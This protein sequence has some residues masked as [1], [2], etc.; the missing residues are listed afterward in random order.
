MTSEGIPIH[1]KQP[2]IHTS[3]SEESIL[4]STSEVVLPET[5][6]ET[7]I[8]GSSNI[9]L[10]IIQIILAVF[11]FIISKV[12]LL[13]TF[14]PEIAFLL[15]AIITFF[16]ST[17]KIN[18]ILY[19]II[20][21]T[22]SYL[23]KSSLILL[24][25]G[26]TFGYML[27][28][29]DTS[30]QKKPLLI[31]ESYVQQ[32]TQ[33]S[34]QAIEC[35]KATSSEL[36]ITPRVDDS[37]NKAFDFIIRD[38]IDYY[39]NQISSNKDSEFQIHVRNAMN[40]MAT[41][42][43]LCLQN[44][45]KVELGIMSSFAIAN[46]FIVHLREYKKFIVT[47]ES[48]ST[49]CLQ[50]KN[51]LL[52]HTTDR[53]SQAQV[54]RSL[55]KLLLTRLLPSNEIQSHILMTFLSELWAIQI[56]EAL[57]EKICDSDWLNSAIVSYLTDSDPDETHDTT[58]FQQLATSIDEEVAGLTDK[59]NQPSDDYQSPISSNQPLTIPTSLS[60]NM[61]LDSNVETFDEQKNSSET[62]EEIPL[63]VKEVTD[64]NISPSS[65]SS[66]NPPMHSTNSEEELKNSVEIHP[67]VKEV[68][69]PTTPPSL[70]SPRNSYLRSANTEKLRLILER[71]SDT[72][73]EFMAFLE[74][75]KSANLLRFWLQADSFKKIAANE[76][77]IDLIQNDALRIF[78][79]YF[80]E[81]ALYPV[82]VINDMLVRQCES[83]ISKGP[84]S[85]CFRKLQEYVFVVLENEY[86]DDFIQAMRKQG[87]DMSFMY[88][89][90]PA[91]FGNLSR[92]EDKSVIMNDISI[93]NV[94]HKRNNTV[95]NS[96]LG[97]LNRSIN[98]AESTGLIENRSRSFSTGFFVDALDQITASLGINENF[99]GTHA[100]EENDSE[101][102][103][104][105]PKMPMMN[106]NGV[107]I[108]MTDISESNRLIS[109]TKSRTYMIEVEQP[110]SAGWIMTRSFNDFETLHSALGKDFPKAEKVTMPRLMWKKNHE[111]C[112]SLERYLNILLS[113]AALCES[114]PLQ[115]FMKRDGLPNDDLERTTSKINRAL[116]ILSIPR[117]ISMVNLVG[118]SPHD[119]P[120]NQEF[121]STKTSFEGSY[122]KESSDHFPTYTDRSQEMTDEVSGK[123][124]PSSTFS[125]ITCPSIESRASDESEILP[126]E[127]DT[128]EKDDIPEKEPT[129]EKPRRPR[130][131]K[132]MTG[133]DIDLLIDT[134][135]DTIEEIFD[136]SEKSQWHLRKTVLSVLRGL[137]RRSYTEAIKQYFLT[138]IDSFSTEDYMVSLIDGFTNSFW[139]NGVWAD[140]DQQRS[141]EEK[142]R[143]KDEAKR[144]LLQKAIPNS[145][146][147]V[148]GYEN[149]KNMVGKLVD[150]FLAEK[151]VVRGMGINILE[152]VIKLII[153]G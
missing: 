71:Q 128:P 46:N 60:T 133:Q 87:E 28:N 42:L 141:E 124:S 62:H 138:T 48:L 40:V 65:F 122:S 94:F 63:A 16:S 54:L 39:Y 70:V 106:L 136:L 35:E 89:E 47:N 18:L 139:P 72:F 116:S 127:N 93:E 73:A 23:Q 34:L 114:E 29:N 105:R 81:T 107:R 66:H 144:L 6:Q 112:K 118:A 100:E 137:V 130:P 8:S 83:D 140:F 13:R 19:L 57:L 52:S 20:C 95:D 111:A 38:I 37:L 108:R 104:D 129:L 45:D 131:N 27:R 92:V 44:I 64:P 78:K 153:N 99:V 148:V 146:K 53:E 91:Q 2:M 58:F 101:S 69:T 55:S 132:Q 134:I 25:L 74:E 22:W 5:L 26:C 32:N 102:L 152:N 143:T 3:I 96:S 117:S 1:I 11:K 90:K 24:I 88:V 33:I 15:D 59:F 145:L 51:S 125:L 41:N 142:L 98:E 68:A 97:S 109:L 10:Q 150:G 121:I 9:I 103:S 75:R 77:N 14:T 4:D 30:N 86:F 31:Q 115:K 84:T 76:Q 85:N 61:S 17:S 147:Q 7:S 21:F 135:F 36:S 49:Y 43:S 110:G 67:A 113:D 120:K 126:S 151:E 82:R 123:N 50:N 119:A 79:T 12:S 80:G 149:S 56:F